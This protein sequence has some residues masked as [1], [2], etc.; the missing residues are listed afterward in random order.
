MGLAT[1]RVRGK[2]CVMLPLVPV[3]PKTEVPAA[4]P[5]AT[6]TVKVLELW[7]GAILAGAKL[8]VT[9]AGSPLIDKA[10]VELN[11]FNA[12]TATTNVVELPTATLTPVGFEVS[13]K[14]GAATVTL[15]ARARVNPPP[16]PVTVI[17]KVAAGA[18]ALALTVMVT[19]ALGVRVGEE[20][21][22]VTPVGAPAADS[23][24]GELNPPC[25]LM[26]RVAVRWLPGE[27]VRLEEL[28][29]SEKSDAPLLAQLLT[30]RK[31]STE[32]SPVTI[33]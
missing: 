21:D 26:V 10:T 33:S 27:I 9:P 18:P 6:E 30:S 31:A 2:F 3:T 12:E 1:A 16:V 23:V 29:A 28:E 5:E 25:A 19:G 7:P 13:A 17:G 22:S 8:A 15:K 20:K 14:L 32:P 24:T 11:P 4:A